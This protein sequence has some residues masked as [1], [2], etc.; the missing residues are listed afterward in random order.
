M[1]ELAPQDQEECIGA[2]EDRLG[3]LREVVFPTSAKEALKNGSQPGV[4]ALRDRLI[5]QVSIAA[6]CRPLAAADVYHPFLIP[7]RCI[8]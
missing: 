1:D 6:P 8:Q 4:D 2:L 3:Y 7:S 5:A